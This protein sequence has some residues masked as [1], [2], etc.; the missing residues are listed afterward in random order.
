M[1]NGKN[2]QNVGSDAVTA[3][4]SFPIFIRIISIAI[5]I[6]NIS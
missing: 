4:V 2:M 3:S 1:S 6:I 5:I